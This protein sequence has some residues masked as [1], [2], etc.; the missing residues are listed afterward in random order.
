MNP[1]NKV[2]AFVTSIA[3]LLSVTVA[4]GDL[5][6]DNMSKFENSDPNANVAVTSSTPNTFMGSAYTLIPGATSITG[7]DIFPANLTGTSFTGL[8]MTIY[9]WG[10]V[11]MGTVNSST[12]A[13]GNLLRTDTEMSSGTF[14]SG[15][16]FP[17]EGSPV[18]SAPGITLGTPIS[19]PG[20]TIG[21]SFN[22]MGTTDG[23]TYHSVNSLT[24]LIAYGVTPSVGSQVFNGYY[25][26][27]NSE[28]NGN[29]ISGVRS[30]GFQDQSLGIRIYGTVVPEPATVT[31]LGLGTIALLAF[32][33]R[34]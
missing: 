8:K 24:S 15:F 2:F 30:L 33:R 20:T 1:S 25:R 18:G 27:A 5:L 22:F 10:S 29:F 12:P 4:R 7:F 13:F 23:S 9:V 3:L 19:L 28:A 17:F 14:D 31:L 32:H 6:F 11:N 16:Y 26:N 21:V 34:R